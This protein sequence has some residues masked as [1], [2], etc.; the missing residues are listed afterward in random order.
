MGTWH[1]GNP[2]QKDKDLSFSRQT[3][4]DAVAIVDVV[5]VVDIAIIVDV[6]RVVVVVVVRGPEPIMRELPI[7]AITA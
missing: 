5:V 2:E 1:H 4:A 3:G 7:Q 6:V